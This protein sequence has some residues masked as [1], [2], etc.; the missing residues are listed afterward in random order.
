MKMEADKLL[1]SSVEQIE[2]KIREKFNRAQKDLDDRIF[3]IC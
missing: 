1:L 3:I 2:D